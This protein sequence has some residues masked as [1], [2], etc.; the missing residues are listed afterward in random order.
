MHNLFSLRSFIL[1][2]LFFLLGSCFAAAPSLSADKSSPVMLNDDVVF[3]ATTDSSDNVK[4]T[5][6]GAIGV[7][8]G[9]PLTATGVGSVSLRVKATL[10]GKDKIIATATNNGQSTILKITVVSVELE[11]DQ[12]V[13]TLMEKNKF[14]VKVIPASI[15]VSAYKIE[16]KRTTAGAAWFTL[17]SVQQ[18]SGYKQPVAGAFKLRGTATIDGKDCVSSEKDLTVNFPTIDTI[19]AAGPVKTAANAAWASTKAATSEGSR[20]EEGFWIL[21]DTSTGKYSKG[22]AFTATPVADNQGAGLDTFVGR[23]A[24]VPANPDPNVEAVVYPVAWFHTHTPTKFRTAAEIGDPA[25]RAT[26]PSDA[27]RAVNVRPDVMCP[28]IAYDYSIAIAPPLYPLNSAAKMYTITPPDRR[29]L[30]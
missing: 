26:G 15:T 23:P 6:T 5:V 13:R 24:D 3:T 29:A 20:R 10:T 2:S 28:G 25:G 30:P 12:S 7:P 19:V 11:V 14:K 4:I 21:I 8:D 1:A 9:S 16:I 18:L 17:A 22:I 27:D